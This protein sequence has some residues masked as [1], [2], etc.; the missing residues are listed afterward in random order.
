[1]TDKQLKTIRDIIY[2]IATVLV[3]IGTFFTIKHYTYGI[4]ILITGFILGNISSSIDNF[5]L[6]KKIKILEKELNQKT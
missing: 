1:M 2:A 3:L 5:R 6:K 4:S